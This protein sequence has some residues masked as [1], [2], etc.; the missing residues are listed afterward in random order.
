[1]RYEVGYFTPEEFLCPCCGE[2]RASRLLVLWLDLLRRGWGGPLR[3]NSGYRCAAHNREVGGVP[4][5][6]HLVGCA[7]DVA[8]VMPGN[9]GFSDLAR[10]L[11]ALPGWELIAH[12]RYVHIAVPVSESGNL[13]EGGSIFVG[14]GETI[15]F[16]GQEGE[17]YC[18]MVRS[19][20]K[21][22]AVMG[23]FFHTP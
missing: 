10:R 23:G 2:G 14:L 9:G 17:G 12:G 15:S 20:I 22:F 3:V 21:F 18:Q 7:A 1:M 19:L 13:W 11:C 5:S 4:R 16:A 6:R 8:P